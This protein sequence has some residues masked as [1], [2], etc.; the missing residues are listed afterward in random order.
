[1]RMSCH[2][3]LLLSLCSSICFA[4]TST[5]TGF[6]VNPNG[7]LLT[8]NHVVAGAGRVEVALGGSA[9]VATV[10]AADPA[11]DLA[12]V[13][14]QATGLPTLPLAD[15]S[16]VEVGTDVRV[17]G[18]P[19]EHELGAGVKVTRGVV[20]GI[21]PRGGVNVFQTDAAVNPGNSGGPV[22]NE[23]GEVV[24][25]AS[26]KLFGE[27]VTAVGFVVINVTLGNVIEP[28][29]MGRALGLSPLVVLIS[30]VFWWWLWGPVGAL[31]SAP[32]TMMVKIMLANTTDLRWL[33]IMLGSPSWVEEMQAQWDGARPVEHKSELCVRSEKPAHEVLL[34]VRATDPPRDPSATPYAIPRSPE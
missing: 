28:R 14:V 15:S 8:C 3:V 6:V 1:M 17:I 21:A 31:L 27:L 26:A 5:G 20:S 29:I 9:Y 24:G 11:H 30:M 2:H 22:V 7:Y 13:A 25:V 34:G 10:V 23:A 32:L 12:V 4:Q 18:F 19:L 16:R 33:A